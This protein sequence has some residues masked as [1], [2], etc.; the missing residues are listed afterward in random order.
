MDSCSFT[1]SLTTLP[2][3]FALTGN[4]FAKLSSA[5]VKTFHFLRSCVNRKVSKLHL[6]PVTQAIEIHMLQEFA[7]G[8]LLPCCLIKSFTKFTMLCCLLIYL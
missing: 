8:D 5:S 3:A 7:D 6:V 2:L 4:F 1:S